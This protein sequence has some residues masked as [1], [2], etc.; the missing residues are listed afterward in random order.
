MAS[1]GPD[2]EHPTR[3]RPPAAGIPV[4]LPELQP[5]VHALAGGNPSQIRNA[6]ADIDPILRAVYDLGEEAWQA[7]AAADF[8]AATLYASPRFYLR[9]HAHA[10]GA[11][12]S[13]LHTHKGTV[14]STVLSGSLTNTSAKPSYTTQLRPSDGLDVWRCACLADGSHT[15]ERTGFTAVIDPHTVVD[16]AL[17]PGQ[18]F[19]V[20]PGDYHRLE[21]SRDSGTPTVTLCLFEWVDPDAPDAFVLTSRPTPVIA[22]RDMTAAAARTAVRHLLDTGVAA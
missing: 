10:T 13:D 7:G 14:Y 11:R 8:L 21:I 6:V 12:D 5:I 17:H 20:R 3:I 19:I 1:K 2:R 18:G 22:D 15:Q 9:L 16:E 4:D